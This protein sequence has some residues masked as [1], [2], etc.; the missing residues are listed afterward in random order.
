MTRTQ[1]IQAM[2]NGE[3]VCH[4]QSDSYYCYADDTE[5]GQARI[6]LLRWP[7]EQFTAAELNN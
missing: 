1:A 5:Y 4:P 3:K 6:D 7:G 2:L